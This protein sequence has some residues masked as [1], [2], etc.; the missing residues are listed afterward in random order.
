[1]YTVFT[2][3]IND[4][5]F[6]YVILVSFPPISFLPILL[7]SEN[8]SVPY[9]YSNWWIDN[10]VI[11]LVFVVLQWITHFPRRLPKVSLLSSLLSLK[12]DWLEQCARPVYGLDSVYITAQVVSCFQLPFPLL[13]F[14]TYGMLGIN[15]RWGF[16]V[17]IHS[18]HCTH[19]LSPPV[20]ILLL[21]S[22]MPVIIKQ[23]MPCPV[24][25]V[26][27][28]LLKIHKG[29]TLP[30]RSWPYGALVEAESGLAVC[31][32][33]VEDILLHNEPWPQWDE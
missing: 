13:C 18:F 11:T 6:I 19:N 7:K 22:W 31:Y 25:G 26:C 14:L 4:K 32:S 15:G 27:C 23:I 20:R 3:W 16:S 24:F 1:M 30:R 9:C 29:I 17:R 33:S 28:R 10:H 5:S 2:K 21:G 12:I 8:T